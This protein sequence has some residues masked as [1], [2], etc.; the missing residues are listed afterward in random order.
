MKGIELTPSQ[1]KAYKNGATNICSYLNHKILK[2][3][4]VLSSN[5]IF[6]SVFC[7]TSC[8][9]IFICKTYP[10]IYST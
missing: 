3:M 4:T 1:I 6:F 5:C 10:F 9:T 2:R 8:H 7:H